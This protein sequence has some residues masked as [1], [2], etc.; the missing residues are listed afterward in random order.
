[1]NYEKIAEENYKKFSYIE[2]NQYIA[3]EYALKTIL[4]IIDDFKIQSIL[5]LGLGIGS[6]SDTVFKYSNEKKIDIY[7]TGTEAN[8]FCLQALKDNVEEYQRINLFSDIAKIN[9]DKKY[10]LIIV[11][12]SDESL[13]ILARFTHAN[14]IVFVEGWRGAQVNLIK[15]VFPKSMHVEIIASYKNPKY[16]PFPSDSWSGG[17]QLILIN[18]TLYKK[19]YWFKEKTASFLKRRLRKFK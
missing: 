12:G 8:D 7:Y 9:N 6:I 15:D 14:T 16:G 10:D 11:D 13:K 3:T 4:R 18:P 5:E 1:M 2:G 19:A 17:G